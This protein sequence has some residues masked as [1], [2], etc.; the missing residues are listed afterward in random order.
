MMNDFNSFSFLIIHNYYSSDFVK[1]KSVNV[2][3]LNVQIVG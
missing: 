3:N 1:Y 2:T